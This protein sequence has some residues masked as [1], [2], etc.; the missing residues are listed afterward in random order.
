[1]HELKLGYGEQESERGF[2]TLVL[3][4]TVHVQRITA[5]AGSG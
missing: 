3:V 2:G 4:H 1:L 5:A